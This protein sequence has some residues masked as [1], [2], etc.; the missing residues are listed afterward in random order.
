MHLDADDLLAR[1]QHEFPHEY[2]LARLHL[3]VD[4]QAEEIRR[5]SGLVSH[6]PTPFPPAADGPEVTRYDLQLPQRT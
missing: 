2:E 3:L 6:Q 4:R 5:L 1:I